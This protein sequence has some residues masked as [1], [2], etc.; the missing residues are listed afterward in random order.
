M[1]IISK[2]MPNG[3]MPCQKCRQR[4]KKVNVLIEARVEEGERAGKGEGNTD[5]VK[6]DVVC[7]RFALPR[8][9]SSMGSLSGHKG[10]L[11]QPKKPSP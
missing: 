8:C 4:Y 11:L 7:K 2:L 3:A 10:R 1:M 9:A 5:F 6:E